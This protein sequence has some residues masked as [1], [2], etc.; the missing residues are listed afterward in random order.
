MYTS[1]LDSFLWNSWLLWPKTTLRAV[2]LNQNSN[3]AA[4]K[5]KQ[6]TERCKNTLQSLVELQI[7][8]SV[9]LSLQV[10]MWSVVNIE[11]YSSF[12]K[13]IIAVSCSKITYRQARWEGCDCGSIF[14]LFELVCPFGQTS[15][16]GSG[17]RR[18]ASSR[19]LQGGLSV[20]TCC[21]FH[22]CSGQRKTETLWIQSV[23]FFNEATK[24]SDIALCW[25]VLFLYI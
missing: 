4:I 14:S 21:C 2:R 6:E 17:G 23:C 22:F 24:N 1:F 12:K 19:L 9:S 15:G 3:V 13:K 8:V 11:I 18:T 25:M 7:R 20:G 16:F 5:P 10:V